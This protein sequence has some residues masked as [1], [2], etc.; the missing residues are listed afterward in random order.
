M[1]VIYKV[2]TCNS[3]GLQNFITLPGGLVKSMELNTKHGTGTKKA[4]DGFSNTF[5]LFLVFF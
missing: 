3:K 1:A 4:L 2:Y 5:S